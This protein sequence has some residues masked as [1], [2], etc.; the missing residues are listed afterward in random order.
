MEH[1]PPQRRTID[2]AKSPDAPWRLPVLNSSLWITAIFGTLWFAIFYVSTSSVDGS[3]MGVCSAVL[4]VFVWA[5]ALWRRGPVHF[6]LVALASYYFG[7]AA[8]GMALAGPRPAPVLL[9]L[10]FVL[11]I[12]LYRGNG[13][14]ILAAVAV[15]IL[16]LAAAF[17]WLSGVLPRDPG[18]IPTEPTNPIF[19]VRMTIVQVL[20]TWAIIA[21][22]SYVLGNLNRVMTQL[23]ESEERF[24]KVFHVAP[25]PISVHELDTGR[26]L[27]VN[28]SFERVLGFRRDEVLGRTPLELKLWLHE[29]ERVEFLSQIRKTGSIHEF[30]HEIRTRNGSPRRFTV[31]VECVKI[32]GRR[33]NVSALRDITEQEIAESALKDSEE[34]F[35]LLVEN[36]N[37]L[38]QQLTPAGA[39]EYASPNHAAVAG[40]DSDELI[41]RNVLDHVH[42]KDAAAVTK[43]LRQKSSSGSYRCRFKDGPWQWLE[44]TTRTYQLPSGETHVVVVSRDVTARTMAE[45]R[46]RELENQLRH[47]QKLDA[48]GTLAGGIAHDFNNL[49][50][51]ITA[52]TELAGMDVNQPDRVREHLAEVRV[53]SRRAK[54]LVGQILAFSRRQP[55][56]RKPVQLRPIIEEA[57][58]LLRSTLPASI[59]VSVDFDD[60]APVVLADS[61]QIH[62]VIVNL[63]TNSAHAM[64]DRPGKLRLA[65]TAV[66]VDEVLAQSQPDLHAGAY[67]RLR[68]ADTGHGMSPKTLARAMEPFF[69]TKPRGKGTGLGL[70]VVHGIVRDHEGAVIIESTPDDGTRVDLFFPKH[71]T[72]TAAT[73][74]TVAQ[75]PRGNGERILFVDDEPP[76][77]RMARQTLGRL[78]YVVATFDDPERAFDHFEANSDSFDLVITDLSMPG[79]TG[80]DLVSRVLGL[81]PEI[82]V[83]LLTGYS[84]TWNAENVRSLGVRELLLKPVAIIDLA[85]AVERALDHATASEDG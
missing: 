79:I 72:S 38:I 26:Y 20:G 11:V 50:T 21:I 58:K 60:A 7:L 8:T 52:Y 39:I 67:V 59:D 69:T 51:A 5:A 13:A 37:E 32:G 56:V 75:S 16:Y 35:R 6:R 82:P 68:V 80:T 36:S 77:C 42:P 1:P 33:C 12:T 61:S 84:G 49:L 71:T 29:S 57:M 9:L 78:G 85:R 4:L 73:D 45:Q 62:Q 65:L 18:S 64:R 23:R 3:L 17:G 70:A 47:A 19:W 25:D 15:V 27:D 55:Q 28:K 43:Q 83:I 48:L 74:D 24:S 30:K 63:C 66:S 44:S 22:V 46:R 31:S 81:R 14:G 34:R 76:I 53:A 41:G 40:V 54:D 10:L 2:F